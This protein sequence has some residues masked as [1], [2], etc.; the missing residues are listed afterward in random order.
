MLEGLHPKEAAVVIQVKDKKLNYRG[1]T[2]K[3]VKST[4]P[5]I[6]P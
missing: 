1:L 4:F 3:L 2:H 6:L 5:E